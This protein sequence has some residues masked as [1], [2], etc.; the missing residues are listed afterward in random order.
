MNK[1]ELLQ[2]LSYKIAT[3]EITREEIQNQLA[4]P[5]DPAI[6]N[7]P[8]VAKSKFSI[9]KLLYTLGA[10]IAVIGV[11]IFMAQIWEDLGSA[12]RIAVT[13][14]LGILI[15]GIG[16]VL[17]FMKP[18]DVIGQIFHVIGGVLV[19]GGAIV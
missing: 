10:A 9:V 7:Q 13:F 4:I 16:S 2:Q 8:I 17:L 14:G 3:G 11:V 15:A 19:P 1:N 5:S 12:G 6:Q 18:E